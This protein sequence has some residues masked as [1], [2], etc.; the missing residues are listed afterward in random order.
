[1]QLDARVVVDEVVDALRA[2]DERADDLASV[3]RLAGASDDAGLDQVDNAIREQLGVDPELVVVPEGRGC[4]VRDRPNPE[5][6]RRAVLDQ[7]GDVPADSPLLS[8]R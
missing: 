3:Q 4:R 6:E 5:L 1:M 2:D 8:R 7:S